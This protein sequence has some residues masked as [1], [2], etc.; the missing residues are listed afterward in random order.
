MAGAMTGSNFDKGLLT[1]IW[2]ISL[3]ATLWVSYKPPASEAVL[4]QTMLTM[5]TSVLSAIM[6][7]INVPKKENKPDA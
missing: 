3:G 7:L 2:I 5:V 6:V 1:I 4:L